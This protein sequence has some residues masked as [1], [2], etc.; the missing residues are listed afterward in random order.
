[1]KPSITFDYPRI[2]FDPNHF[3]NSYFW[4]EPLTLVGDVFLWSPAPTAMKPFIHPK[5][6]LRLILMKAVMPIG[7]PDFLDPKYRDFELTWAQGCYDEKFDP[8]VKSEYIIPPGG[9][10]FDS[11]ASSYAND[12]LERGELDYLYN[13]IIRGQM[14]GDVAKLKHPDDQFSR[15][16]YNA[17]ADEVAYNSA[18]A[19]MLLLHDDR[20]AWAYQDIY[21]ACPF[22]Y[23]NEST[24]DSPIDQF[25]STDT[26]VDD[27]LNELDSLLRLVNKD[28][29]DSIQDFRAMNG[30]TL[31]GRKLMNCMGAQRGGQLMLVRNTVREFGL[32]ISG[33]LRNAQRILGLRHITEHYKRY[34]QFLTKF[35]N[36][37][38]AL[39]G[40]LVAHT[41]SLSEWTLATV[42]SWFVGLISETH[43]TRFIK[44]MFGKVALRNPMYLWLVSSKEMPSVSTESRLSGFYL[45]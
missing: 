28:K 26:A 37:L 24:Q 23:T 12:L 13:R 35:V 31:L 2:Y 18:N 6:M 40:G 32:I 5:T 45:L 43:F 29:I 17:F 36:L 15:L 3:P 25:I 16:V 34:V 19:N 33:Q 22:R 10:S 21:N 1:M 9:N 38:F 8:A 30:H 7:K 20:I 39:L 11:E 41:F 44:Y 27:L 4:V 14:P 42:V